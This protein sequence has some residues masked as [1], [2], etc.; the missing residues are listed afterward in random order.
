M[1]AEPWL[2]AMRQEVLALEIE[3]KGKF[4]H[5]CEKHRNKIMK[6]KTNPVE[7][8]KYVHKL[9]DAPLFKRWSLGHG[10]SCL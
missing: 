9:F 7:V 4:K 1:L 5:H 2:A 6:N 10:G 3:D 8:W